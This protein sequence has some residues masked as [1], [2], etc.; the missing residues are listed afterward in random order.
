MVTRWFT[1]DTHYYHSNIIKYCNR[2]FDNVH[3]MNEYLIHSYND[4]VG[5][6]DE[7]YHLG[8]FGF[9][10]PGKLI[11]II[12][13]L[14]G[15]KYLLL[16]NHDKQLRKNLKEIEYYFEWIG[17]YLEITQQDST[18]KEKKQK[19]IMCH[20]P[21]LSWNKAHYG[22]WMLHGHC[23]SSIDHLNTDVRRHDVG[24][25]GNDYRPI[26]YDELKV[27]MMGREH[28]AVDHHTRK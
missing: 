22:S 12:R 24:V 20:Y 14:K 28:R 11:E 19:I 7:V 4:V 15:K 27:L 17:E 9:A 3:E 2:P 21:I 23:H 25:D 6:K 26:S 1:S 8:D 10:P 18:I 13:R 16:G 5:D